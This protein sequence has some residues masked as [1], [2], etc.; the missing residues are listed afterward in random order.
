MLKEGANVLLLD[1]PTND[2]DVNT[3]RA[4]E[5]ALESFAARWLWSVMT[6][7]SLIGPPLISWPLKVKAIW[8]GSKE[9]ILSMRPTERVVLEL[10]RTSPTGS[11][12]DSSQEIRERVPARSTGRCQNRLVL[13][14]FSNGFTKT[15]G[16]E[17][18]IGK[19]P[20]G[21]LSLIILLI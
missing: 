8:S 7:G 13:R 20:R 4:L 5:Q 14:S 19:T 18:K 1:E 17:K 2:L 16:I 9:T 10:Q 3:L 12:T 11:N 21:H 15:S 6:G